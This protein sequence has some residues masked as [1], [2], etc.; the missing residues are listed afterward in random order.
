M[1]TRFGRSVRGF[2]LIEVLITAFV[3]SVGLLALVSLQVG[4]LRGISHARS[5]ADGLNLAEHFIETLKSESYRWTGPSQTMLSLPGVFPHLSQVGTATPGGTSGWLTGYEQPGTDQRVG[6]M[7]NNPAADAG[8]RSEFP[9]DRG[10]QFCLHYRLTWIVP[11]YLLRADVRVS[12]LTAN[13]AVEVYRECPVSTPAMWE[14]L[15]NVS[16]ITL[17][18]TVMRNIF[19]R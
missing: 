19:L 11:E 9:D 8:L 15:A 18:G 4:T 10:R 6:S 17:S 3:T 5:M 7:G 13:S 1:K 2:S 14:D 12:W 16:N